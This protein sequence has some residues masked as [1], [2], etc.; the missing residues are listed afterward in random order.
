MV[1]LLLNMWKNN[2]HFI[3]INPSE[4]GNI[5]AA[6]RAIKNMGFGNLSLVD[7]PDLMTAEARWMARNAAD[8]LESSTVYTSLND[9]LKDKSIIIGTSRRTGRTRGLIR[10]LRECSADISKKADKNKV[11]ILFGREDRGLL[12]EE[13][14]QCGY[15]VTI[16]THTAQPS[17]NLAQSVL[18]VAYELAQSEPSGTNAERLLEQGEIQPV[19]DRIEHVLK[20]LGYLARGDRDMDDR[21]VKN[22]RHII[23]RAGLTDWELNMIYG[24]CTQIE[25]AAGK[26]N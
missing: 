25:N 16:P 4:P 15:L 5:G 24:I 18:L 17:I 7:P 12:N 1:R 23:S 9:A 6:A 8:V 2:I 22:V 13:V 11:A 14:E 19:Y 10:T 21:I 3:L 26:K 20:L